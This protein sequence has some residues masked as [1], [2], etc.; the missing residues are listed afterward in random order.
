MLCPDAVEATKTGPQCSVYFP[1]TTRPKAPSL[2]VPNMLFNFS[3]LT[4]FSLIKPKPLRLHQRDGVL[5]CCFTSIIKIS[6]I[7]LQVY[8]HCVCVWVFILKCILKQPLYRR[9]IEVSTTQ[10]TMYCVRYNKA[11]VT[12]CTIIL[13]EEITF[14]TFP[15]T[16]L[17]STP[18]KQL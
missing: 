7:S 3:S 15:E 18:F 5:Q 8:R 16:K 10:C 14:A 6:I 2:R 13:K 9:Q 12:Y 4:S 17:C 11:V 1:I